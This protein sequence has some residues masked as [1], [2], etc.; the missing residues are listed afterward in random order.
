MMKPDIQANPMTRIC[1]KRRRRSMP[2]VHYGG[3]R[4]G[5]RDA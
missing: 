5:T 1:S 3:K 2:A 4:R